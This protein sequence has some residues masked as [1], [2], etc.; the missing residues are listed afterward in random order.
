MVVRIII[1][2]DA[3]NKQANG[4]STSDPLHHPSSTPMDSLTVLFQCQRHTHP[5]LPQHLC[6]SLHICSWSVLG[7]EGPSLSYSLLLLKKTVYFN[8]SSRGQPP[9][10]GSAAS[11]TPDYTP[12]TTLY[13]P[14]PLRLPLTHIGKLTVGDYLFTN[15]Q[16]RSSSRTNHGWFSS[17]FLSPEQS[18]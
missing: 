2:V 16:T 13:A 3:I 17:K 10:T 1:I 11:L 18:L 14:Q 7:L 9:T 6:V 15:N 8:V 4:T 5:S 12:L